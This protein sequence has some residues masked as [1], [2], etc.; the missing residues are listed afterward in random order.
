MITQKAIY[1]GYEIGVQKFLKLMETKKIK[2]LIFYLKIE[3]GH[4]TLFEEIAHSIK[5]ENSKIKFLIKIVLSIKF[6]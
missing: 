1:L 6:I 4:G 2:L 3:I 5:N